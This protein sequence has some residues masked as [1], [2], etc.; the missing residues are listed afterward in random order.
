MISV[1]YLAILVA[2]IIQVA[3]GSLWYGPLFGKPW[4]KLIGM[5]DQHMQDAKAKGMG[6]SY[7][8]M[9]VG[10]LVMNWVLA[11]FITSAEAHYQ[12]W[13]AS[14]G[15]HIAL[16]LWLGFILPI[17]MGSMLWEG[18]SWKLWFLN[19]GYYLVTL[20]ITG[21]LLGVWH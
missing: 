16:L 19:A 3:I 4:M 8:M 17:T 18:K 20:C 2:A 9:A 5:T 1:N 7:A 10:A 6:G 15:I 12:L 21:A 11:T 13:T 14:Y